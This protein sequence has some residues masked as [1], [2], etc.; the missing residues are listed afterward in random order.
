MEYININYKICGNCNKQY[1]NTEQY[2]R[3]HQSKCRKCC[4]KI[5][6]KK[7]YHEKYYENKKD[8]LI[9]RQR[10]S[11]SLN[12]DKLKSKRDFLKFLQILL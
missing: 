4:N 8:E 3:N 12:K 10:K 11:Y 7:D 6:Y 9:I 2:F 5:H 1:E